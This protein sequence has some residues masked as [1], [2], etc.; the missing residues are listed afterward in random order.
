MLNPLWG[1]RSF[2]IIGLLSLSA[3]FA[4]VDRAVLTGVVTDASEAVVGSA[5]ITVKSEATGF[6][7]QTQ[8]SSEGFYRFAALPVGSYEVLVEA[9][10]FNAVR[11][12]DVTL[13]VGQVRSLNARL[14]V[15]TVSSTVEIS[16]EATP[17]DQTNAEIGSVISERQIRE[18]PLNGRHWA[19][20]MMLAPGAVNVG[21]GNQNS[22]RFFGRARD[23]NN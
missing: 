17:L 13:S 9:P 10:G 1:F 8:T 23:D 12:V 11:F 14:E 16:A 2:T 6:Q 21:E 20:L 4:Q 19:T 22:I 15:S 18:M 5:V 3:A 7:R